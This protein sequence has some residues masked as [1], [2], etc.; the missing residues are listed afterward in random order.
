MARYSSKKPEG[1]SGTYDIWQYASNGKV[2]GISGNVD[3]NEVYRDF[4]CEIKGGGSSSKSKQIPGDPVND[5]GV[6][7]KAHCRTI[8]DCAEV[9]DGQTAGWTGWAA[10]GFS[11]GS[12]GMKKRI[13]AV[14]V[15]IVK[16]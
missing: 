6:K 16:K 15:K 14:Q 8:G 3:M 2:N 5:M 12:V 11:T 13:E 4:P 9:Q 1:I 7:Y 10:A